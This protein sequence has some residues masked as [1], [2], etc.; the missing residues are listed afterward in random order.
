MKVLTEEHARELREREALARLEELGCRVSLNEPP[1][2]DEE[3]RRLAGTVVVTMFSTDGRRRPVSGTTAQATLANVETFLRDNE[4]RKPDDPGRW[5]PSSEPVPYEVVQ[6][7]AGATTHQAA[8]AER[9]RRRVIALETGDDGY[10][11][12]GA[13][14]RV[15]EEMK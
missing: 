14:P 2:V 15:V 3:G 13:P 5:W 6:R 1:R 8:K 4:R 7:E 10:A 12:P 11:A 9:T